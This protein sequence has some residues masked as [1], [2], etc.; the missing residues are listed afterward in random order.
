[1]YNSLE[2]LEK[3]YVDIRESLSLILDR[4]AAEKKQTIL[5]SLDDA[6]VNNAPEED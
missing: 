4:E 6:L 2:T 1:M 5:D 3:F